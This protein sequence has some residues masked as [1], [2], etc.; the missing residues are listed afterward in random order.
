MNTMKRISVVLSG[1]LLA[2]CLGSGGSS[3]SVSAP[4]A[5]TGVSVAV[6]TTVGT[7]ASVSFTAP[8]SNGGAAITGYTVTANPGGITASGAASPI[9]VSGLIAGTDYT[10]SVT[11]L[12]SAGSGTAATAKNINTYNIVETFT[13]PMTLP[14]DTIFTGTFVYN[15]IT[16]TVSNLTGSITQSMTMMPPMT[17]V[18]LNNQLSSVADATLGG[19]LVTTFALNTVNTLNVADGFTPDATPD[20][21]K[22]YGFASATPNNNN[23]Y[24]RIFVN[25]TDPTI[26]LTQAQLDKLAYAD[27]TPGGMM[28]STCMTGTT[29]AGYGRLG[30]MNG[31]PS[32]Q[33][34]TKQ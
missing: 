22:Y 31:Y 21:A 9:L 30:S 23:A 25:T 12:N 1:L 27:C 13:E 5:P 20:G 33:I 19:L 14:N 32:S 11:A 18:A 34:I 4:G 2:A 3:T 28:M 24:A 26:A 10:F 16:Q 17:T 15:S 29:V 8:A 6:G 7:T